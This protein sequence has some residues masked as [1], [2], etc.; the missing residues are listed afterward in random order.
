MTCGPYLCVKANCT[1]LIAF[2]V[3]LHVQIVVDSVLKAFVLDYS[4][5]KRSF[6]CLQMLTIVLITE[7]DAV[8][9]KSSSDPSMSK[10]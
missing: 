1:I 2:D 8:T 6:I 7:Y 3:L 4:T 5:P 9:C 10:F